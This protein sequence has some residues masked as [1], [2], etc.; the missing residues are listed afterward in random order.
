MISEDSPKAR[1]PRSGHAAEGVRPE[2]VARNLSIGIQEVKSMDSI[3][4]AT[5]EN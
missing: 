3:T 2:G 4:H 1:A 5:S